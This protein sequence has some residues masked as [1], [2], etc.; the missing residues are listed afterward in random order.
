MVTSRAETRQAITEMK[1]EL[2]RNMTEIASQCLKDVVTAKE[3][4]RSSVD[5]TWKMLQ[6]ILPLFVFQKFSQK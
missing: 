3:D 6:V 5:D 2:T 1:S 4:L